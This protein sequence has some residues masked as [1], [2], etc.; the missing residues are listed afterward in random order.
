MRLSHTL[1]LALLPLVL[2]AT[3]ATAKDAPPVVA[4]YALG[5]V[6][7]D[8]SG[9]TQDDT[10]FSLSDIAIN[11]A[12]AKAAVLEIATEMND[13][14]VVTLDKAIGDLSGV[15]DDGDVDDMLVMELAGKIGRRF[16]LVPSEEKVLEAKTLADF[17]T[18]IMASENSPIL[19]VAWSPRCPMCKRIYDERMVEILAETGVRFVALASNYPDKAEHVLS[20]LDESG[21]YWNVILDPDQRLTDRLG[22]RKTP[23]LFLL[24]AN[25]K[26]MFRGSLDNDPRGRLEGDEHKEY[27]RAAIQSVIDGKA[28]PADMNE[29]EPA[30]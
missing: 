9:T 22:G 13:G 14:E 12:K 6:V 21:Y 26:L 16:G 19:L 25:R 17:V 15:K 24:D 5:D 4:P 2:L 1:G 3:V 27:L 11:E 28:I 10:F 30:G 20:Y 23:H 29:S 18:W 7:Y 8:I